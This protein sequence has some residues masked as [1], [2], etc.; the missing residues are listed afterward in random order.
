MRAESALRPGLCRFARGRL[1]ILAATTLA[2]GSAC[3]APAACNEDYT[4]ET[5]TGGPFAG[6][7][8]LDAAGA[9]ASARFRATLSGLPVLWQATS[10]LIRSS[11]EL[12]LRQSY[13]EREA[14]G[15]LEMPRVSIALSA[16]DGAAMREPFETSRYPPADGSVFSA[17]LFDPCR[18]ESTANCCEY[19]ASECSG[20]WSVALER[21][22]GDP[23]PPME[24][25]W[26][27]GLTV[28][29]STCPLRDTVPELSVE[30]LPP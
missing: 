19:G 27:L 29:I 21:V 26:E 16:G 5:L 20:E 30:E 11:L 28:G 13:A 14:D 18:L 17:P 9:R 25:S 3:S 15:S 2:L 4:G 7:A 10:A 24:L 6:G 8:M 22:D 12:R 1:G 23:F